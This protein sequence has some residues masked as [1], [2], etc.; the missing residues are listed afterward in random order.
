M[1]GPLWGGV[2]V[3]TCE[4]GGSTGTYLTDDQGGIVRTGTDLRRRA[5]EGQ[6]CPSER[7][8]AEI[9]VCM[10][11]PHFGRGADLKEKNTGYRKPFNEEEFGG[12]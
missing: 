1:P 5:R 9:C 11:S 3:L 7:R 8:K 10:W 2:R 12:V 4:L 6:N